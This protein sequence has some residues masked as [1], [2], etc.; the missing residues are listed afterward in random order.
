[1]YTNKD[2]V[3]FNYENEFTKEKLVK[4][5]IDCTPVF[6]WAWNS[7]LSHETTDADL[8]EFKRMGV[9]NLYVL[10]LPNAFTPGIPTTMYCEYLGR[11]YMEQYTYAMNKAKE[12]GIELWIYDEG[13]WPSGGACNK[14]LF[15]HPEYARKCLE[16]KTTM[17]VT[18]SVYTPTEQDSVAF[19]SWGGMVE[20][21]YEFQQDTEVTEYYS[22]TDM[23]GIHARS[24]FPDISLKEAT[25]TFIQVTHEEYKK[26]IGEEFGKSIKA[27]FTDEPTLPRPVPYRKEYEQ[28]FEEKYGYSIKPY[29]QYLTG[30][31]IA[32]DDKSKEAVINY[33]DM[34]A[35]LFCNNFMKPCKE[36]SNK[37]GM[38][39][40]GHIDIDHKPHGSVQGGNF[41]IMRAMRCFDVPGIDVIWRQIFRGEKHYLYDNIYSENRFYPRYASSAA[42]Q[43]G[44]NRSVTE[45]FGVFG[46]GLTFDEMR[47][48]L[49]FQAI[50]GINVYNFMLTPYGEEK[51]FQRVGELPFI[52][53][54]YAC[55]SDFKYFNSYAERL[56][57]ICSVG[58]NRTHTAL[59]LPVRDFYVAEPEGPEIR[60]YDR[61]GFGMED[62]Q[63]PFDI[64][65]DD[66]ILL[67]DREKLQ[68]GAISMGN[69][70]YKTLVVTSCRHMKPEVKKLLGEFVKGG[71]RVVA[72]CDYA[73]EEIDGAEVCKDVWNVIASP[74]SFHGDTKGLRLMQRCCDNAVLWCIMNER[75]TECNVCVS[76]KEGVRLVNITDGSIT[77]PA[78]EN[79]SISFVM[80]SG[81][82][83]ALVYADDDIEFE[84][85]DVYTNEINL[86]GDYTIRKTKQFVIGDIISESKEINMPELKAE[87]GDWRKYTGD[88]F[89]GSCVYRTTFKNP[90]EH[91]NMMLDLGD[92]CYTCEAFVNG[93]S[94]GVK[95]MPPYRFCIDKSFLKENNTLE[96]RV[97]NTA[98]NEYYY[99]DKF[100]TWAPWQLTPY[101]TKTQVFHKDSLKSGLFGPV[102]ILY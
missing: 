58:N 53:E 14:V 15:S 63:I 33:Y 11:E 10:P 24:D 25:D 54:K 42:T 93:E 62:S 98:A 32:P 57:Y 101:Y 61:V 66:V 55:Y 95:V 102:K 30:K 35:D 79:G 4:P 81:E 59:Y 23:Y 96:I 26:H 78:I 47:Y 73:P 99:T 19:T 9:K 39:F 36:W 1:M 40:T 49:G 45:T 94:L 90:A 2:N 48:I 89:S 18:G 64:F 75:V 74:L 91:K 72:T 44:G 82:M 7:T 27:V 21:G 22:K 46:E 38:A 5:P 77:K 100:D 76:A 85:P 87:L 3:F 13:G 43:I 20:P 65:D 84:N 60:E 67:A 6:A 41:N 69:A 92:V 12:M 52:K 86:N 16:S 56:S 70:H 68:K 71:G 88:S 37:H 51:G 80:E 31:K 83:V 29:L 28:M 97:S 17:Y 8:E 34:C 50:R